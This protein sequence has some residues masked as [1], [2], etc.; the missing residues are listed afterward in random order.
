MALTEDEAVPV[1][2]DELVHR[3]DNMMSMI[4][5]LT[6]KVNSYDNKQ[7]EKAAS[8]SGSPSTS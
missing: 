5:D 8:P 3:M 7:T 6:H 2:K 4:H 1:S